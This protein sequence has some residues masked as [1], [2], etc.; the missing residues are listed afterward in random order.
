[1]LVSLVAG[2]RLGGQPLRGRPAP[3]RVQHRPAV[4]VGR[5]ERRLPGLLRAR[6]E[7]VGQAGL[8]AEDLPHLREGARVE[9]FGASAACQ[10]TGQEPA[11]EDRRSAF[12][13]SPRWP[14]SP[15]SENGNPPEMPINDQTLKG[16]SRPVI[17][18]RAPFTPSNVRPSTGPVRRRPPWR[19]LPSEPL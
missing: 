18:T 13:V 17:R 3:G 6:R 1:Q 12:H 15:T 2:R 8:L 11:D 9:P 5:A 14:A 7:A 10:G 19:A 16:C 4:V